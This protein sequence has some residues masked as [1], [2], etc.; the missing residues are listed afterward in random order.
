MLCQLWAF[1]SSDNGTQSSRLGLEH[2]SVFQ[3]PWSPVVDGSEGVLSEHPFS[4]MAHRQLDIPVLMGSVKNEKAILS[5]FATNQLMF[6]GYCISSTLLRN[7]SITVT[8]LPYFEGASV[9]GESGYN[10]ILGLLA[11]Q[12]AFP[13]KFK[14]VQNLLK[15]FY[16]NQYDV[17]KDLDFWKKVTVQ[18]ERK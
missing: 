17:D 10:W 12:E 1:Q 9:T 4:S 8:I 15:F 6:E 2:D 3:S 13:G 18:V 11:R 7:S 16:A 14:M 5:K